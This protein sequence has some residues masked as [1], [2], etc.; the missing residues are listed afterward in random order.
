VPEQTQGASNAQACAGDAGAAPAGPPSRAVSLE[1]PGVPITDIVKQLETR[2][3]AGRVVRLCEAQETER[4]FKATVVPQLGTT[5]GEGKGRL[6]TVRIIEVGESLNGPYYSEEAVRGGAAIFENAP[7]YVYRWGGDYGEDQLPHLPEQLKRVDARGLVGNLVGSLVDVHYNEEA[8]A[9]DGFLKVYDEDL[10]RKLVEMH[11]AGDLGEGAERDVIGLSIDAQGVKAVDGK[12]VLRFL[13]ADSVDVVTA[14][15]AGGRI[16]RL[17]A[18]LQVGSDLEE[19]VERLKAEVAQLESRLDKERTMPETIK[20]QNVGTLGAKLKEYGDK[21]ST[22]TDQEAVSI[23]KALNGDV[24]A[25]LKALDPEFAEPAAP[26]SPP[27][28]S[29][30]EDKFA[31]MSAGLK[32]LM[33]SKLVKGNDKLKA[34]IADVA[35][36][37][38]TQDPKDQEIAAL[39]SL[40][41]E[42]A[43]ERE[44]N[45]HAESLRLH[46]PQDA[47]RLIDRQGI[48]VSEDYRQVSGL[49]EA[50]AQLVESKPWVAK[51]PEPET[52]PAPVAQA[53]TE[54]P[55]GE[56]V[57]E[58]KPE[59]KAPEAAAPEG[60][61]KPETKPEPRGQDQD[62]VPLRE[63]VE[64]GASGMNVDQARA[65]FRRNAAKA[66]RGDPR[67]AAVCDRLRSEFDF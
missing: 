61:A 43:I 48:R 36:I 42:Q 3:R 55:K 35:G 52:P 23:L 49:K 34:A 28:D 59:T 19:Q 58:A 30:M 29:E 12:T 6:W 21:L 54:E 27:V 9:L 67:A 66:R 25:T 56:Q 62:A 45:R 64:Q 65:A 60:E 20:E 50:L 7:V 17:V 44:L 10:R 51:A 22:A 31:K 46:S 5:A 63:A 13:G 37:N 15:A 53:A 57:Q 2:T 24:T 33:E 41:Q 39:K 11:E 8:K 40:L 26:A 18:G 1:A 32:D 14:P 38:L 16:R 4:P 47:M